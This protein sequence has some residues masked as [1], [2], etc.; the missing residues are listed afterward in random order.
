MNLIEEI[1]KIENQIA[2]TTGDLANQIIDELQATKKQLERQMERV[3]LKTEVDF[4]SLD[5]IKEDTYALQKNMQEFHVLQTSIRNISSKLEESFESK[6]GTAIQEELKKHE[7]ETSH[8][9]LD[10][11]VHLSNSCGKR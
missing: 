2:N 6:T 7:K 5:I 11:Y 10:Q 1:R 4:K 9:L 8:N 3:M